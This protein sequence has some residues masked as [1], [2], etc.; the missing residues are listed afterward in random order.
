MHPILRTNVQTAIRNSGNPPAL[1]SLFFSTA[2]EIAQTGPQNLEKDLIACLHAASMAV[3][4]EQ[5]P[6]T[7]LLARR[8]MKVKRPHRPQAATIRPMLAARVETPHRIPRLHL[9]G[10]CMH[11]RG[12][13]SKSLVNHPVWPQ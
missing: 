2:S 13:D 11:S 9:T 4:H 1:F 7:R 8:L 12:L 5:I 6:S 3:H 10:P